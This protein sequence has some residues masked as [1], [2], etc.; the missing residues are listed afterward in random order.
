MKN[1]YKAMLLMIT[2]FTAV[3]CVKEEM[4]EPDPSFILTFQRDGQ[5]DAYAGTPFY[6][7]PTGSGEFFTLYIGR[8]SL[9]TWGNPGAKGT[10]FNLAD[11][12]IVQYNNVGTY[13][14]TLVTSSAGNFGEEYTVK[15]KTVEI[16]VVDR[17]NSFK[18]FSINKVDGK[19]QPNNDILFE[20]PDITTDFNFI[21][22]F[23]MDSPNAKAFV[24]GVEQVTKE[25]VNDF[26]SPVV[27]TVKSP[28]GN[29]QQYTVKFSTFP[30]SSEKAITK[31]EL[32]SGTNG[33]VGVIDEA[34]KTINLL[35][36]YGTKVSAA[37]LVLANSY[38]SLV[39]LND[40]VYSDRKTYDLTKLTSIKVVAQDKTEVIYTLNTVID[41]AVNTFTFEGLV[42]EPMGVIDHTAKT[43]KVDVLNGTDVENLVGKWTGSLGK[44]TIGTTTQTNGVTP[45]NFT[46]PVTYTFY[47]GATAGDKYVVTVNIK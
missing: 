6:I 3:S 45:N 34:N 19:F 1:M 47:K 9:T 28:E 20:V 4:I 12:L 10:D 5:T 31:F 41:Y 27:Y 21:A 35:A 39:Y 25:T 24:N 46:S 22:A 42:P 38:G 23:S 8:D 36:N 30:S 44:V 43:I 40:A 7:I 29:D 18:I 13:S 14:L 11:S 37:K 33:E 32:G 15:S 2:L 17:R 26:S 16:N